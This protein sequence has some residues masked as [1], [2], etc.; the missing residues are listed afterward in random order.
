MKKIIIAIL[1]IAL[2]IGLYYVFASRDNSSEERRHT[3]QSLSIS[4]EYLEGYA[5][6]EVGSGTSTP[7]IIKTIVLMEESEYQSIINGEREGGEGPPSIIIVGHENPQ[8]LSPEAWAQAFPQISTYE[9]KRGEV[10]R[11]EVDGKEAIQY[12]ADGLYA[13]RSV[14]F[15]NNG[16][17]Y[18]VNG[19]YLEKDSK[20]YKDFEKLVG[21]IKFVE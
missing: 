10:E 4:F 20:I 1:V 19:S 16:K 8:N 15:V 6:L 3:D 2:G 21:S 9:L 14:V 11:I 7:E 17:A 12:E 18:I 13:N 5:A